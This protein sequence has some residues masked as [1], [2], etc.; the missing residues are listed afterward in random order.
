V[1][2]KE[3]SQLALERF[4]PG[5]LRPLF[6]LERRLLRQRHHDVPQR[7]WL[8]PLSSSVTGISR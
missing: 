5:V 6:A 3:R 8:L 7:K 2:R 1:V 4:L